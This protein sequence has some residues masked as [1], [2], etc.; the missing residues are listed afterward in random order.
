[1]AGKAADDLGLSDNP[2]P[3]DRQGEGL[4]GNRGWSPGE[5]RGRLPVAI[6]GSGGEHARR[7]AF[8]L[9]AMEGALAA[10]AAPDPDYEAERAVMATHRRTDDGSG[11]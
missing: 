7:V 9:R 4:A 6:A 3:S 1:M 5:W 11:A 8:Y 10:L 2:A